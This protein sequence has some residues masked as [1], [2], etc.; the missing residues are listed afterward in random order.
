MRRLAPF[1]DHQLPGTRSSVW[2]ISIL[3][4]DRMGAASYS[5]NADLAVI[6]RA[7]LCCLTGVDAAVALRALVLYS[8]FNYTQ[9][10]PFI[11]LT[12]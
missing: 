12:F 3:S 5:T 8:A 10:F 7:G 6:S 2:N 4:A 9:H 11:Y 1:S